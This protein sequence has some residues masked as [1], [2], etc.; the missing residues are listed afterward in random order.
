MLI[1]IAIPTYRR[2]ASLWKHTLRFLRQSLYP[3]H[4][5][6][7]FVASEEEAEA[8]KRA[9]PENLYGQI[10]VG[11]LGLAEQRNFIRDFYGEGEILCEMDDDVRDIKSM[12]ENFQEIVERGVREVEECGLFGVLPNDDARRFK[13]D[14]TYHLTHILGS[15]FI[16]KNHKDIEITYTEK[17]DYERSILY[18][19]RYGK[20]ARYRGA[21][22]LT[23]Y[24]KGSGGLIAADRVERMREGADR[25][26]RLYPDYCKRIDKGDKPDVRLDWRAKKC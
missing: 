17:E 10:V 2:A 22:V 3:A 26:C 9:T 4:L 14:T 13:N 18:F 20:V 8:Y 11:K 5:I 25:L 24:N 6:T 15:F 23:T 21:G 7:L 16:L 1:P 12:G 19:R